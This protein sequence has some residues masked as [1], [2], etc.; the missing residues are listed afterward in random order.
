MSTELQQLT[1]KGAV[2]EER[3]ETRQAEYKTDIAG[4]A[5]DLAK[6]DAEAT[7]RYADYKT[8]IGRLAEDT[9]RQHADYKTEIGRLAE[10]AAKRDAEAAKR[11]TRLVITVAGML[12]LAVAILGTLI[13]F[14]D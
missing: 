6:R 7:K 5:A 2:L 3:M 1:L 10:D 14:Q 11:E 9:V 4:L 13:N 8:E 12:A